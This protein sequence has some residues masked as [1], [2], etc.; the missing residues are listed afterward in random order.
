M[1]TTETPAHADHS[2][3]D[4]STVAIR[5]GLVGCQDEYSYSHIC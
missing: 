4:P 1:E 5:N 3:H 2:A